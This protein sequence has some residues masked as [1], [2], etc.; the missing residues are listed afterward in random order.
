MIP[1][2]TTHHTRTH[3]HTHTRTHTHTPHLEW[4]ST[5]RPVQEVS[6]RHISGPASAQPEYP[7]PLSPSL[8]IQQQQKQKKEVQMCGG[9]SCVC[10]LQLA[11]VGLYSEL[12]TRKTHDDCNITDASSTCIYI[13]CVLKNRAN[14]ND[15]HM[16][17][18]LSFRKT[19]KWNTHAFID[20]LSTGT[21]R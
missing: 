5:P 20:S 17:M 8:P 13:L 12:Y 10:W 9:W 21:C 18:V 11:E 16:I 3:T 6:S 4:S 7:E 14:W 15:I 19:L 2:D 1:L